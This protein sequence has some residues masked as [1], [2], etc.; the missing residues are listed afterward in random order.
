MLLRRDASRGI[1]RIRKSHLELKRPKGRPRRLWRV[2]PD[3]RV[4]RSKDGTILVSK[5]CQNRGRSAGV[6]KLSNVRVTDGQRWE[7]RVSALGR[8]F[9][10]VFL[11]V[12]HYRRTL[13]IM[14]AINLGVWDLFRLFLLGPHGR[15]GCN[16]HLRSRSSGDLMRRGRHI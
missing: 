8:Q 10:V 2:G 3:Q 11:R 16:N 14:P 6:W 5:S 1:L 12:G 15:C 4:K 7:C 13:R 9:I